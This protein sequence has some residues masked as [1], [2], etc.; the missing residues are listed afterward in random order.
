[1]PR[2]KKCLGLVSR[3]AIGPGSPALCFC[4]SFFPMLQVHR[5]LKEYAFGLRGQCHAEENL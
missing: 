4:N 5:F 3:G 1:M 2:S